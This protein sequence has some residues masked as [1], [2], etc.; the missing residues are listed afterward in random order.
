MAAA[1]RPCCRVGTGAA[2]QRLHSAGHAP[3]PCR[4]DLRSAEKPNYNRMASM[5]LDPF[6]KSFDELA[7]QIGPQGMADFAELMS[8]E[9]SA[10]KEAKKVRL[11]AKIDMKDVLRMYPANIVKGIALEWE[12][13]P[14]KKKSRLIE[15]I[16][17]A[18]ADVIP[19]IIDEAS[20]N[21]HRA[22]KYVAEHNNLKTRKARRVLNNSLIQPEFT[23]PDDPHMFDAFMEV[24][25]RM[26]ILIVGV[27]EVQGRDREI[28]TMASD[29]KRIVAK[30]TGWNITFDQDASMGRGTGRSR[31]PAGGKNVGLS[32]GREQKPGLTLT[33]MPLDAPL[34]RRLNNS[35]FKRDGLEVK[36]GDVIADPFEAMTAYAITKYRN[37]FEAERK[38]CPY[39]TAGMDDTL[40]FKQ[41]MT[42]FLAEWIN[43]A[44]GATIAEE[45]VKETV[46]DK[47]TAR[48]LLQL[49]ELFFD[50]FE[51]TE[52]RGSDIIAYGAGTRKT[53]R[54]TTTAGSSLYPIGSRFEGRIHPYGKKYKTCGIVSR[55]V[56]TA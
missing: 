36:E 9:R 26:G 43:P 8:E 27:R 45:F 44:T 3:A 29:V 20:S 15:E 21:E 48:I 6:K 31:V 22:L 54:I 51:V 40:A 25:I 53:Y 28:V 14:N 49:T 32:R 13:D 47:K 56:G 23:D 24:Y 18:M 17:G 42:W 30:H 37:E 50:R 33:G 16:A 11:P 2:N 5:P 52:H 46:T 41:H 34:P 19:D 39:N 12:L 10:Y 7:K 1:A 55:Y 4:A 35:I 38:G